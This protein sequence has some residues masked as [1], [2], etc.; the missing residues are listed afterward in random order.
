[1]MR[2]G[3]LLWRGKRLNRWDEDNK[4]SLGRTI[5]QAFIMGC[6]LGAFVGVFI[7]LVIA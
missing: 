4:V 3:W 1:M 6:L 5:R 2:L 7:G